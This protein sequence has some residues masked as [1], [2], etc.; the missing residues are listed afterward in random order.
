MDEYKMAGRQARKI[1]ATPAQPGA[2]RRRDQNRKYMLG[3]SG[4]LLV[5]GELLRRE[6]SA[7]VTYGNAKKADVIAVNGKIAL[8]IEI[9]TT[10]EQKWV[11]GSK[12]PEPNNSVWVLVYLPPDERQSVEYFVLTGAELY[13]SMKL[14]N[15]A[16]QQ[17]YLD[18]HGR[19][20]EGRGVYWVR[21]DEVSSYREAWKTIAGA[22]GR[23][24]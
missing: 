15:D 24:S 5:T 17:K 22:L 2:V 21:Q 11:V 12:M 4:E 6:I 3:L 18:K 20:F 16:D 13:G 14:R 9:K 8:P 10:Q 23:F 7:A 19:P 1:Q